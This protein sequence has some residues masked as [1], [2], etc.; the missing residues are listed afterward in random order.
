[1]KKV[2][3]AIGNTDVENYLKRNFSMEFM[4]SGQSVYREGVLI[5][6]D[7]NV[8]DILI[9]N[10]TLT[11]K[12][13]I[14]D[15]VKQIREEFN[16]VRIIFIAQHRNVGDP[17]LAELV[18]KGVYDI[19]E[20]TNVS[21]KDIVALMRKPNEYKDVSK[22][23]SSVKVNAATKS[24]PTVVK[25]LVSGT[26][27][28]ERE[29][30]HIEKEVIIEKEVPVEIVKEV[31]REVVREVEVIK[32][33]EVPVSLPTHM[34]D[35]GK[36]NPGFIGKL[37]GGKSKTSNDTFAN[38]VVVFTGG[39][40]GVGATQLALN[41]A[42]RIAEMNR[43]VLF[44]E[45]NPW[46]PTASYW[47]DIPLK[48]GKGIDHVLKD[49]SEGN[50]ATTRSAITRGRLLKDGIEIAQNIDDPNFRTGNIVD[51]MFFSSESMEKKIPL[52]E[53][54]TEYFKEMFLNL[55]YQENYNFVIIDIPF[56]Y[57]HYRGIADAFIYCHK[58]FTVITQD[59]ASMG[60]TIKD[61]DE[62]E[63]KDIRYRNKN[64]FIFNRMENSKISQKAL[65]DWLKVDEYVSV[66]NHL[67]INDVIAGGIPA[68]KGVKDKGFRVSIDEIIS[69]L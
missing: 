36:S 28:P 52:H 50:H 8:P 17:V 42:F 16:R 58:I 15:L 49:L 3:L 10:E 47:H 44:L 32:E 30:V 62:L 39:K 63:K 2:F 69:K 41:T 57:N 65:K 26:N 21:W 19:I 61:I 24:A 31:V 55:F 64:T 68:I 27:N 46:T 20:G 13:E 34:S 43:K 1:M 12:T 6:M 60:Y 5:N 14:L 51:F 45:I 22:Y 38:K 48:H 4:F 56:A 66:K 29:Y 35:E 37:F 25:E 9:L 33:I 67:E 7:K 23:Q 53:M 11:G 54:E 40:G 18:N 59:I